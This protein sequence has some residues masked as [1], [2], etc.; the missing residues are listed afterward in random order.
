MNEG[1]GKGGDRH[2]LDVFT[3]QEGPKDLDSLSCGHRKKR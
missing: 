2:L 3:K 1:A